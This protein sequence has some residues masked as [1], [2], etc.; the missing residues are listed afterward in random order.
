[1]APVVDLGGPGGVKN[2]Q[3]TV[4]KKDA[5]KVGKGGPLGTPKSF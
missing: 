3:K 4:S 1:M 5:E 2:G